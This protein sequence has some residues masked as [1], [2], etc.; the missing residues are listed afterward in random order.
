MISGTLSM[1]RRTTLRARNGVHLF[2]SL[3][4]QLETTNHDH[5]SPEVSLAETNRLLFSYSRSNLNLQVLNLFL[6]NHRQGKPVDALTLSCVVKSCGY[7][8]DWILGRQLHCCCIKLGCAADVSVGT[9]LIDMYMKCDCV[10]DARKV[11]DFMPERNVVSWTSLITGYTQSGLPDVVVDLFARMQVEGVWPN[12]YTFASVLTSVAAR[13][14]V[15]EGKQAHAQLI[16]FGNQSTVF[17]CNSLMNMYS[18]C[19]CVDDANAV[20]ESVENKDVVS[21]NSM[22]AGLVLNGSDL[23][24]LKL[25]CRM[26]LAGLKPTQL[27]FVTV[28]KLC[29]K[30]KDLILSQQLHC[31]VVKD[32]F[33]LDVNILTAL[34]VVY[35]K[36]GKMDDAFEL[37]YAMSGARNVVSWTAMICAFIQNG[38]LHRAAVLFSQMMSGDVRPNEFTFSTILSASPIISP[39]QIHAQV[40]KT[41]YHNV[42]SVGTALLAAYA[43]LGSTQNALSVFRDIDMKDIVAWSAMMFAFAQA[44]D[45]EGAAKLY[46]EMNL[47][48]VKP[49]EFT[50]S[51]V[52]DACASPAASVEQGKQFHGIIIKF[53]YQDAICVS[54]ALVTMYAK[55]G[56][57]ENA[58]K[59][60]E[61]QSI[62]DLV[63]WNSIISGYAQHGYGHKALEIFKEMEAQGLKM[64]SVTFL[65]VIVACMHT[66]LVEEGNKY[67]DTMVKDHGINPTMEHYACMV[68]LYSRS[69]KLEEALNFIEGMPF[70]AGPMI[71]RTLLGACRV[72]KNVELGKF[73]A[74]QLMSLEPQDSAAYVLLSNIYALTGKWDER[75]KIRK[76]MNERKVKKEAGRSWIQIKNKVHS[77]LAADRSHPLSESIYEKLKEMTKRLKDEGYCADTDLVLHEVEEEHKETMLSRHSERLAIAFGLIS[78]PQGT[79]LQIVKNLRVCTDCHTAIKMISKL[80]ER[81]IVVRDSNRFHHFKDGSC[82]C[83]DYW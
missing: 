51:S 40:I 61:R 53:R 54:S 70:R 14:A 55:K 3:A 29:A 82:S 26:K 39:P 72:H 41:N 58:Q 13:G 1:L 32:G 21:W 59:V 65:G 27:T 81:G 48:K 5:E 6:D 45:S 25:F 22:I 12:S 19:G 47:N 67:F 28:I 50:L 30:L 8:S 79:P 73:A 10:G 57:I 63:S 76:L 31:C 75:A 49:N 66:G 44:G 56:S 9:A 37:F 23:E 24:A 60:F 38:D 36:C 69:G 74:E 68:D 17:V 18:K 77:F 7:L 4:L 62:R 42:S 43:K 20:F 52:I 2:H 35:S 71:W 83:G 46:S 33:A 16:K 11:F 64:D 34:M 15:D 78:T 80:E